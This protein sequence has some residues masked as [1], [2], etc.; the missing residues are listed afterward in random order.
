MDDHTSHERAI[1]FEDEKWPSTGLFRDDF[2]MP[3]TGHQMV[4]YHSDS[5]HKG[6]ASCRAKKVE[7]VCFQALGEF[8]RLF[9]LSRNIAACFPSVLSRFAA[10]CLP[11]KPGQRPCL[12]N[13]FG[14][15]LGIC[16]RGHDFCSVPN[17]ARI[18]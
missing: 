10:D 7:A 13:D 17:N 8:L 15:R 6:V 12:L 2:L 14:R 1:S 11:K 5:L 16:D 9:G 3:E 4:V 18:G